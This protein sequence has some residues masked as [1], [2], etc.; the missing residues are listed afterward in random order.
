VRTLLRMS[1]RCAACV[2]AACTWG[3]RSGSRWLKP[4]ASELADYVET[5]GSAGAVEQNVDHLGQL[6]DENPVVVIRLPIVPRRRLHLSGNLSKARNRD[7]HACRVSARL[8]VRG[9]E[10][11][12]L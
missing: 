3:G 5:I 2:T 11:E 10:R 4:E 8:I 9:R 1:E 6:G 7:A 12:R